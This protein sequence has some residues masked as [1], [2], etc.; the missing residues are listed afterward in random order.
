MDCSDGMCKIA[1][2]PECT[3]KCRGENHGAERLRYWKNLMDGSAWDNLV[4]R[5]MKP[6]IKSN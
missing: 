3:C 5:P 6:I 1:L 2:Y 4:T